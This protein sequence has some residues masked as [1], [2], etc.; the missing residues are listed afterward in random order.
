MPDTQ[1]LQRIESLEKRTEAA[2]AALAQGNYK[3]A[4]NQARDL[5]R[6]CSQSVQLHCVLIEAFIAEKRYQEA[7][8]LLR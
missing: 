2:K 4:M 1:Q 3:D 5:L 6:D 7:L 8:T